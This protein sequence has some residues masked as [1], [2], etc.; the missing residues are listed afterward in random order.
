M[1]A[2]TGAVTIP[3]NNIFSSY[4]VYTAATV[5]LSSPFSVTMASPRNG[6]RVRFEYN[7]G[8]VTL[9]VNTIT[10]MGV[11]M[12]TDYASKKQNIDCYY[13]GSAW[14]VDYTP[15]FQES[16]IVTSAMIKDVA[17]A[18]ITGTA[19]KVMEFTAGGVGQASTTTTT[20]LEYLASS[21]P[22]VVTANKA[23]VAGASKVIDEVDIT[24]LKIG[25]VAITSSAAE[26][27]KMDGVT[28]TF[29]EINV[30]AGV[31]AGTA[32][33]SKAVVLSA[34]SKI[35]TLDITTPKI[36]G[37][38]VTATAAEINALAGAGV[39]NADFV[40]IK[41]LAANSVVEAD[42]ALLAGAAAAGLTAANLQG[43][44]TD[45]AAR[46]QVK[47]ATVITD[48]SIDN[49]TGVVCLTLTA[50]TALTIPDGSVNLKQVIDVIIVAN[51]A[52]AYNITFNDTGS[53][54]YY[55]GTS[56]SDTM[57]ITAP[58]PGS[59]IKLVNSAA[60]TWVIGKA[61]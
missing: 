6:Q 60:N 49:A 26:I 32:A 33:A 51:A 37:T 2:A 11:A 38:N 36:N 39:I 35:D 16:D 14:I 22:G 21:S 46:V 31:T 34:A 1:Q 28:A 9:G 43:V 20:E 52:S 18:K 45:A 5:T 27:N 57:T 15:A 56:A 13:N 23:I 29:G 24:T 50:N 61:S 10:F 59:L 19:S 44:A 4:Y 40:V 48:G 55:A 7:P 25:G 53:T 41:D 58:A 47:T 17:V 30:L 12:P 8:T 3:D 42:L 54:F